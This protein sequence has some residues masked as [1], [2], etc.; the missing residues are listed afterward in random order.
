MFPMIATLGEWRQAVALLAAAREEVL[1]RG[2]RAPA[3]I[4]TGIMVETPAAALLA[5]EFA[6]EVDF[7][8]I[9]TNDLTQYTLAAERGNPRTAAL[10]DPLQPAVLRLIRDVVDAGHARSKGV[11]VCGELA[12]DPMAIP[13]LVGLG[14]DELSMN[15]VAIPRSVQI[16]RELDYGAAQMLARE[17]MHA[18]SVEAVRAMLA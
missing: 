6:A 14:V 4:A 5:R 2:R 1:A 12:A 13:L 17:V 7:F 3:A 9:G 11:G 18:G 15:A 8:S 16:V 10:A